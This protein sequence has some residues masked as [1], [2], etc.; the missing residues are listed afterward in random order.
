MI[1]FLT[2][3]KQLNEGRQELVAPSV[4]QSYER[5]FK[6]AL[7]GLIDRTTDP[8]LKQRFQDMM[9][10]PVQDRRGNCHSFSQYIVNALIHNGVHQRYDLE[11]A[12]AY[13]YEQML[14]DRSFTSGQPRTTLFSG[15]DPNRPYDPDQNPL[16][17]RFMTFLKFA[18]RNIAKGKIPR[19]ANQES[20]PQGTVS[21]AQGR[22][23][24]GDPAGGV[25][26]DKIAARPSTDADMAEI[27]ADITDLLRRKEASSGLPLTALFKAIMS[28][29]RMDQQVQQFGDRPTRTMRG[30]IKDSLEEYARSTGNYRLS[31]LLSQFQG[32]ASNKP[33]PTARPAAP[34][35]PKVVMPT[36]EKDFRSLVS[37]ISKFD[38]PV[39]TADLGRYRRRWLEYPPRSAGSGFRNRLEEVLDQMT[40]ANV[41]KATRTLKGAVV[42]GPGPLFNQYR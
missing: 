41:L 20:R 4:L 11:A 12:L 8:A 1:D 36:E 32:F 6:Q 24:E 40:K 29:Q 31:Y 25:S 16:L 17:A 39:G 13:V 21:I 15:F 7:T 3:V 37:V 42:Y 26:S 2:W 5:E 35:P 23:K 10:C 22:T 27:V 38:R 33:M 19:L 28:G 30:I 34:T 18:I 9:D 14:L